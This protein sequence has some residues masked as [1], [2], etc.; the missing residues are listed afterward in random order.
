ML[1]YHYKIVVTDEP[2]FAG[3]TFEQRKARVLAC[4]AGLTI[5]YVDS[6]RS[7]NIHTNLIEPGRFVSP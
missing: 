6:T 2:E 7:D 3:E 4:R 5:T 1:V